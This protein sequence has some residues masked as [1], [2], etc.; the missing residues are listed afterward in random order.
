MTIAKVTNIINTVLTSLKIGFIG[1]ITL[2]T[3]LANSNAGIQQESYSKSTGLAIF[4]SAI[5]EMVLAVI[6]ICLTI[7]LVINIIL[8]IIHIVSMRIS[9]NRTKSIKQKLRA[10]R[11]SCIAH[12]IAEVTS[13]MMIIYTVI[14]IDL[15]IDLFLAAIILSKA[16]IFILNIVSL[17]STFNINTMTV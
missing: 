1:I 13:S 8:D 2:T 9:N 15:S 6:L 5:G 12:G 11:I 17:I 16:S 4:A 10:L 14:N 7:A 3:F